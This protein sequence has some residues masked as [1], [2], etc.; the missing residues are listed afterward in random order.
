MPTHSEH[1]HFCYRR[2]RSTWRAPRR[3]YAAWSLCSRVVTSVRWASPA[4]C[5]RKTSG[6]SRRIIAP[7]T[8][9]WRSHWVTTSSLRHTTRNIT[10]QLDRYVTQH[11]I[12]S[13]SFL[14]P[15]PTHNNITGDCCMTR[16]C[17]RYLTKDQWKSKSSVDMYVQ[18]FKRGCKCVERK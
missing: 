10:T 12:S 1:S 13:H 16:H 18:A 14:Y 2:S 6:F 11:V 7:S 9:I 4:T 17:F 5:W 15:H 3:S 8:R